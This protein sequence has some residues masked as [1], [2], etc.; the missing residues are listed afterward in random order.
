M[1]WPLTFYVD[2]LPDGFQGKTNGPVIRILKSSQGDE[3]LYQHELTHVKQWFRTLGLH[4]FMY[5]LSDKYR[6]NCEIEAY[7]RQ[8]RYSP[9]SLML[10]AGF[11]VDRY[12]LDVTI[13]NV[14]KLLKD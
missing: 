1:K 12:D 3:G 6:L 10:F 7:K 13:S 9:E 5:T 14:L 8:L 4:G 11:I 2:T